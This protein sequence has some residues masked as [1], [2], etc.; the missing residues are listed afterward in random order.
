[1]TKVKTP[2]NALANFTL[3][4]PTIWEYDPP[5][6]YLP[7]CAPYR[8]SKS[9]SLILLCPWTGAQTKYITKYTT[10]YQS[11]FLAT[12]IMVITTTA[13]DLC[14]RNS[15]RKQERLKPAAERISKLAYNY[16]EG[17][18][19]GILMHVFSEGGSNK[20]CE[21]AEVYFTVTGLR[22][23]ISALCF[24]STPGRARYFRLCNALNMSLPRIPVLR[25]IVLSFASAVIG[26]IWITYLG[27][28]GF[29]NNVIERTRQRLL[30]P[31]YFD[32]TI[33][34]CYLYSE[35]DALVAW[36]DV[37]EHA[38][39]SLQMGIP[40]I[41]VRFE[42]SGHVDHARQESERYWNAVMDTWRSSK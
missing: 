38:K 18:D 31:S 21:L 14:F 9:P 13:T 40:V 36:E 41:E 11:Q 28:K 34:R 33:P 15:R 42:A 19:Q 16:E 10:V 8:D 30:N 3:I 32:L 23:P 4:A 27:V 5:V 12:S 26:V 1:M 37:C 29:E 39:V 2:N 6:V 20:A 25:Y 17:R 24:D 7:T 22:L 35:R